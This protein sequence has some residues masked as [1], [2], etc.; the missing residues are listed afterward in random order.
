MNRKLAG[1]SSLAFVLA[2][3]AGV[4]TARDPRARRH[5]GAGTRTGA[6]ARPRTW[7]SSASTS[8]AA[9]RRPAGKPGAAGRLR[10]RPHSSG[11]YVGT[12]ASNVELARGLR[13][14]HASSSLEWD[15]YG[16]YKGSFG[17]GDFG[18]DLGTLYY[19]YPGNG[20][21]AIANADTWEL[22]VGVGWKWPER[23]VLL[24]PRRTT[25]A[26]SPTG[27]G[28]GRLLVPRPL[29]RVSAGRSGVTLI[30]PLRHP[31]RQ[32]RRQRTATKASYND[33]KLGASYT[34]PDG[35]HQGRRSSAP[36][37]S[38]TNARRRLL[39]RPH[40]QGHRARTAGVVYVKKTF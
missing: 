25:S 31:R 19:Y 38:D 14:V 3:I 33:W 22:Y 40:R 8:S 5:A 15:F 18:Y 28:H 10:L 34:V 17:D 23:Q 32:E 26:H 37:T 29:G 4:A 24:Q 12:W 39:H 30:A 20:T 27:T 35:L 2:A 16:G 21:P 7:G 6:H 1:R 13:P 11:F 9:S 36:T